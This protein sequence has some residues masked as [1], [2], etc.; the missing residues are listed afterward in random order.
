MDKNRYVIF[1]FVPAHPPFLQNVKAGGISRIL[2]I[3][4]KKRN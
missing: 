3:I 2:S 1:M 4:M